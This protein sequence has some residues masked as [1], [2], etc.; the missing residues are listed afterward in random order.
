M[1]HVSKP[2]RDVTVRFAFAAMATRR[3]NSSRTAVYAGATSRVNTVP[4]NVQQQIKEKYKG[5]REAILCE[6]FFK[7]GMRGTSWCESDKGINTRIK[8]GA[9]SGG[10]IERQRLRRNIDNFP[11]NPNCN[12]VD[13]IE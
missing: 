5:K 11:T 3:W 4:D 7:K 2:P 9:G 8:D 1:N 13:I 10:R 6:V 12:Q